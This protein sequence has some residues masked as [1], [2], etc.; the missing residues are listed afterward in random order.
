MGG[1]KKRMRLADDE[2]L[3]GRD[4]ESEPL[5]SSSLKRANRPALPP[6]ASTGPRFL[7]GTEYGF[8]RSERFHE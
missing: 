2:P 8:F 1:G 5:L 7:F 4:A 6:V 3:A